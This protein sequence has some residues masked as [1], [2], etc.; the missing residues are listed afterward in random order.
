MQFPLIDLRRKADRL[1]G[2]YVLASRQIKQER[3]SLQEATESVSAA[4][5]AQ[6]VIQGVAQEVQQRAH[7]RISEVVSRCLEA[8][9]GEEAYGFFIKFHQK[10]GKTEAELVL[11]RDGQEM[12]PL[13]STGGGVVDICSLSLRLACL[14]LSVPKKRQFL[15]LDEPAKHLSKQYR[16]AVRQLIQALSHEMGIQFLLI[17]HSDELR[18]GS[19]VELD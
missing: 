19:V 14:V 5:E 4:L 16:P 3:E 11:V 1:L 12:N 17:T 15:A 10:R 9:F 2:E 7:N 6:Q 18:I 13:K 8:V